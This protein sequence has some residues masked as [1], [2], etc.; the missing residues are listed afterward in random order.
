MSILKK[1][2]SKEELINNNWYYAYLVIE[3]KWWRK[4]ICII[5]DF[6]LVEKLPIKLDDEAIYQIGKAYVKRIFELHPERNI[7]DFKAYVVNAQ[8]LYSKLQDISLEHLF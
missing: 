7:K 8:P 3:V 6:E 5:P 4:D 2:Y 1:Y